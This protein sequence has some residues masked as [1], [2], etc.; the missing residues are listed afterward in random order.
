MASW[1][2]M[3]SLRCHGHIWLLAWKFVLNL[4]TLR[5]R[6]DHLGKVDLRSTWHRG[7]IGALEDFGS[8]ALKPS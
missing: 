8:E 4:K 7:S 5:L 2:T 1:R 3:L 6:S